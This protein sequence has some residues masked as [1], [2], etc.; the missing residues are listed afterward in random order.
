MPLLPL[1]FQQCRSSPQRHCTDSKMQSALR[2]SDVSLEQSQTL[3]F[4]WC[5]LGSN[6]TLFTSASINLAWVSPRLFISDVMGFKIVKCCPV[7][8]H[9]EICFYHLSVCLIPLHLVNRAA[10]LPFWMC[11]QYIHVKLSN[12]SPW[13]FSERCC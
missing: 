10:A 4:H 9:S 1:S 13:S 6:L 7:L 11:D 2:D 3:V 5:K 8:L 12:Q